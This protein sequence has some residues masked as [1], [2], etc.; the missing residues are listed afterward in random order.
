ML[1]AQVE[2]WN[3]LVIAYVY[4]APLWSLTLMPHSELGGCLPRDQEMLFCPAYF[5]GKI[6]G[7]TQAAAN[8]PKPAG[9]GF[10]GL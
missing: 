8:R 5:G 10:I 7:K 2:R 4:A 3:V 1:R 9:A 6:G